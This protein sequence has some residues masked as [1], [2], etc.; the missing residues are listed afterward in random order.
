MDITEGGTSIPY[1]ME[2]P[3][4][5]TEYEALLQKNGIASRMDPT[6]YAQPEGAVARKVEGA[7][8]VAG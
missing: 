8:S 5:R 6:W 4:I 3:S 1:W 2:D 7:E